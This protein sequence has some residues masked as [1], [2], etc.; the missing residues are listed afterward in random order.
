LKKLSFFKTHLIILQNIFLGMAEKYSISLELQG[1]GYTVIKQSNFLTF[2][3]GFSHKLNYKIPLFIEI[4]IKK[5]L[6]E[7]KG[8]NFQK[9]KEFSSILRRYKSPE[10]YKGKGIRYQFENIVLKES[11]KSK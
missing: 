3:L 5:K 7:I 9:I 1:V 2:N 10:P 11:K 4:Y 8:C 6:I